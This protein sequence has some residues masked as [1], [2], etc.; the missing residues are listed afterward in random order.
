MEGSQ[1]V[2]ALEWYSVLSFLGLALLLILLI[3]RM[4]EFAMEALFL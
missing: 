1:G 4:N 3:N 2:L